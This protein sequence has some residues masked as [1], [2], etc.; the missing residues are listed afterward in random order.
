MLFPHRRLWNTCPCVQAPTF[1]DLHQS[2]DVAAD[3]DSSGVRQPDS[4]LHDPVFGRFEDPALGAGHKQTGYAVRDYIAACAVSSKNLIPQIPDKYNRL[5]GPLFFRPYAREL[6]WGIPKIEGRVLD[7]ACGSG[8]VLQELVRRVPAADVCGLDLS[9]SMLVEAR[10]NV[11]PAVPIMRGD[12][13]AIP[14]RTGSLEWVFCGFGFMFFEPLDHA[15]CEVKRVLRPGGRL[16]I[17]VWNGLDQNPI[18]AAAN[19]VTRRFFP[20]DPPAFF[21]IPFGMRAGDLEPVLWGQGLGLEES[22]VVELGNDSVSPLDA[23]T[24]LVLGTP[25]LTLIL[26]RSDQVPD[27]LVESVAEELERNL[28]SPID[29]RLSATILT[30]RSV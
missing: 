9:N 1:S 11:G 30:C 29:A 13:T 5:L 26:E 22:C 21:E 20:D 27:G 16:R 25:M 6:V 24:G 28:G 8:I 12:A 15:V 4:E 17:S 18:A 7:L 2:A 14:F 3:R 19:R 10:K 23:A